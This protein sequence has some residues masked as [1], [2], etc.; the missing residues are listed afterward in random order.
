[1]YASLTNSFERFRAPKA[2]ICK[3]LVRAVGDRLPDVIR[4]RDVAELE[5]AGVDARDIR[6]L[7]A[8]DPDRLA[9]GADLAGL[10]VPARML[11]RA[12]ESTTP[13]DL[14]RDPFGVLKALGATFAEADAAAARAG[15][16]AA[17]RDAARLAWTFGEIAQRAGHTRLRLREFIE[18]LRFEV[19]QP[20]AACEALVAGCAQLRQF[21][22]DGATWVTTCALWDLDARLAAEVRRRAKSVASRDFSRV[23]ALAGGGPQAAAA[24]AALACPLSVVTGGPGTGKS[25]LVAQLVSAL[26]SAGLTAR[27]TAPTGKA[28]R[29]LSGRTVHYHAHRRRV[30][31]RAGEDDVPPDLDV[32][33]VDEASMLTGELLESIFEIT[34]RDAHVVLVGDVDQLPPVGAGEVLADLIATGACRVT[35]LT[36][37][38]RSADGV[39]ALARAVLDGATLCGPTVASDT[40]SG[41]GLTESGLGLTESG[42]GLTESVRHVR[43]STAETA[44]AACVEA[45]AAGSQV[46]APQNA[47]RVQ[48]NLLA[49][50]RLNPLGGKATC[51]TADK[52]SFAAVGDRVIV[53]KN[54][55]V[56]RNGDLAVVTSATSRGV[57]LRLDTGETASVPGHQVALAYATTV[58]KF[59]GSET[60]S[61]CLPVLP[62]FGWD[63]ALL[64]TAVTR[65]KAEVV[66]VGESGGA[67]RLRP[68]RAT[69]L[70]LLLQ[71]N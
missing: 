24:A 40:E 13:E 46:L 15:F 9:R 35:R 67:A 11:A 25:H 56:V 36:E 58:H 68:P 5:R 42:L 3:A 23:Q 1:M 14:R 2:A 59:Q 70:R 51:E 57:G 19:G 53:T 34:P 18:K 63:R 43:A 33:I 64:Y 30:G 4:A 31:A 12:S 62:A 71:Y 69:C 50:A 39:C 22:H 16:D 60:E 37:N 27:V 38:H 26:E 29:N 8:L 10:R 6:K 45:A 49:Q 17:S 20:A 52:G 32:M 54:G 66:L 61:V 44:I 41:L 7:L 21:E 55:E 65:A 47:H 48:I 28:A